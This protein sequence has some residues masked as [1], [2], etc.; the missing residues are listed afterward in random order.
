MNDRDELKT[1]IDH[2]SEMGVRF[3]TRLVDSLSSPVRVSLTPSWISDSAE[4]IEYFSLTLSAH[5]GVTVEPLPANRCGHDRRP[6]GRRTDDLRPKSCE[7]AL[8]EGANSHKSAGGG[9]CP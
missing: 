1:R 4:W 9:W 8:S 5:H 6:P 3:V 7:L 2:L